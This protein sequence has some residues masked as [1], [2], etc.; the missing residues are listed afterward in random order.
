VASRIILN[1]EG[2]SVYWEVTGDVVA[3]FA[4]MLAQQL[5]PADGEL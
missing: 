5:G 3:M 2:R 4:Q 1:I